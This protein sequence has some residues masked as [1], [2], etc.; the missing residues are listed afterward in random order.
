GF[1]FPAEVR[2]TVTAY[3]LKGVVSC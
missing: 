3:I 1:V 2:D